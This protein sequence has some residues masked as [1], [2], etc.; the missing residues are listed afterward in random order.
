MAH[1]PMSVRA[2]S[3]LAA[4]SISDL[5]TLIRAEHALIRA[6]LR[7]IRG[8][9]KLLAEAKIRVTDLP[10]LASTLQSFITDILTHIRA[11]NVKL[12]PLLRSLNINGDTNKII[13]DHRRFEVMCSTLNTAIIQVRGYEFNVAQ[14]L[15]RLR[16]VA[17][18]IAQMESDVERHMYLEERLAE[19]ALRREEQEQDIVRHAI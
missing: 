13:E 14:G 5:V 12:V 18:F 1:E 8:L 7:G 2:G 3:L 9:C 19:E 15:A 4:R 16:E 10:R 17:C 6:R 11:E